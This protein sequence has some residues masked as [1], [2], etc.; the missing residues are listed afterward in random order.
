MTMRFAKVAV[1][2]A[3]YLISTGALAAD[4]IVLR[5]AHTMPESHSYQKWVE[6]FRADLDKRVPG[7]I[8]VKVFPSAQLG[9][10]T[11]YLEGMKL[12]TLDG[13]VVGRHGQ[14][15]PRLD[16]LNLPMIFRDEAHKDAVMR[17]GSAL[18]QRLD[19]IM[20]DKGYKV[21]GWGE[22]GFRDITTRDKPLHK[23]SDLA[24]IDIRVPNVEPWLYAF[25]QWGA[26]PTPMDFSEVYSALQQGVINAQEN[27]PEIIYTSKFY[28]VQ[29]YMNLTHHASIPCEFIV[30]RRFWEKL[31]ADLQEAVMQAATTSRDAQVRLSRESNA[32]L[33][34]QLGEKG[35]TIVQDVDRDSFR[36]GAEKTYA[37]Y[38]DVIG[39]D[40]I[41]AVVDAR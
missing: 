26:N 7:R 3:A 8:E 9:T 5:V 21:L 39:T 12:G 20:Y 22:L 33:I 36:E 2:C 18:N 34:S 30:S 27:P 40:L 24:G 11:E 35:M 1:A 4:A 19:Q 23:A 16:V 37:K 15:D 32:G 13:A 28:E 14:I 17:S 31:P 38:G 6:A 10:E 41:Q 25:K 29:K